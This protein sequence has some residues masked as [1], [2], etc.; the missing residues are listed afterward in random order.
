MNVRPAPNNIKTNS[1]LYKK[2]DIN[3][4]IGLQYSETWT[5]SNNVTIYFVK[6]G[7]YRYLYKYIVMDAPTDVP[8]LN[9]RKIKQMHALINM[10]TNTYKLFNNYDALK[11]RITHIYKC[12]SFKAMLQLLHDYHYNIL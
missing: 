11:S 4:N 7:S 8:I 12:S 9:N 6:I 2:I 5:G 10:S 1:I 3:K